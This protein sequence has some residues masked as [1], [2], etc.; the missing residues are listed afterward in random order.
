MAAQKSAG[1]GWAPPTTPTP[2]I[3]T[4]PPSPT[5]LAND[6]ADARHNGELAERITQFTDDDHQAE[7][8]VLADRLER[9]API[10]DADPAA[11]RSL[12]ERIL[13]G[14]PIR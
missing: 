8:E 3:R 6:L 9:H 5:R 10:G 14:D 12:A 4:P 13:R 11:C 2:T 7:V 1:P